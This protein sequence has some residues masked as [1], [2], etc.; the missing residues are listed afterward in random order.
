MKKALIVGLGYHPGHL[1]HMKA[2][3]E[4]FRAL[5][6]KVYR[7]YNKKYDSE[8]EEPQ[9]INLLSFKRITTSVIY[10]PSLFN[11]LFI[12]YL[13]LIRKSTVYFYFHEPFEGIHAYKSSGFSNFKIFQLYCFDILNKLCLLISD[14]ILLGSD[15]SISVFLKKYV[16]YNRHFAKMSLIYPS[17]ILNPYHLKNKKYISYIGTIATDHAFEKFFDFLIR[18]I[19]DKHFDKQHFLIATSSNIPKAYLSRL[20]KCQKKGNVIIYQGKFMSDD[21]INKCYSESTIVWNAYIRGMQ[22]GVLARSFMFASPVII[23]GP[24]AN[25]YV[26]HEYNSFFLSDLCNYEEFKNG[27]NCILTNQAAFSENS[28]KTYNKY[29]NFKNYLE[30]FNYERNKG[31]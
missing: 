25:E 28:L 4:M 15:K 18:A 24:N 3:V 21:F 10:S 20:N 11:F 9:N 12:I 27:V 5:N 23:Y 19:Q 6:H 22:S 30:L 29:F 16:H 31:N 8:A 13:R 14:F 1:L 2:F 17:I 26:T 7:F